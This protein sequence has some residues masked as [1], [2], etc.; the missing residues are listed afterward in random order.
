MLFKN[1][2]LATSVAFAI[3]AVPFMSNAASET[4]KITVKGSVIPGSC[5]LDLADSGDVDYGT[6]TRS[7]LGAQ[8]SD[9]MYDLEMRDVGYNIECEN[10]L[11][12]S[13][14][15]K[16]DANPAKQYTIDKGNSV[17]NEISLGLTEND[18]TDKGVAVIGVPV[19][20]TTVD[21]AAVSKI[22]YSADGT[23]WDA[24]TDAYYP[25][26]D[27][28]EQI[29]WSTDGTVPALISSVAGKFTV[30][31]SLNADAVAQYTD[32]MPFEGVSNITLHYL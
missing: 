12:V 18:D 11:Q 13:L 27:D 14:S 30:R 17:A 23:S 1:K 16:A 20:G 26:Q 8:T 6:L 4:G 22:L 7:E 15:F 29:S 2:V 31:T 24:E 9:N 3:M 5:S 28:S 10:P 19:T 32:A 25:K 21:S